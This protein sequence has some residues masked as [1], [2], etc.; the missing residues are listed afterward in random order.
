VHKGA[1]QQRSAPF[2]LSETLARFVI[3][4]GESF[5][6][7]IGKGYPLFGIALTFNQRML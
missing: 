4:Y 5:L 6:W 3:R 2:C 1:G 7:C